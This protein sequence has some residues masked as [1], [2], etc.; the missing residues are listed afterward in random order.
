MKLVIVESPTKQKTISKFL[1]TGFTVQSSFGHIRDLPQKEFG[2]DIEKGF[3]P[4]YVVIQ[5][6][7][8]LLPTLKKLSESA[9]T[10]ILATDYDREGESIAWHLKMLLNLPKEKIQ[11]ITFHEITKTAICEALEKSRDID[12]NLVNAQQSRRIL[13]RIVGY[14]ISPILWRRI[15]SGLS[16]G[17]VQSVALRLLS[18]RELEISNFKPQ[19]FWTITAKLNPKDSNDDNLVLSS[20]LIEY[21]DKK[22]DK[23]YI[24]TQTQADGIVAELKSSRFFI[25]EIIGKEKKR[26]PMPPFITSTLQQESSRKLGFSATRTM[27]IAQE[28]Y[29][30]IE[31]GEAGSVGLITYHRTDSVQIAEI[32]RYEVRKFIKT[33]VGEQFLPDKPRFYKTKSKSAQEAHEAIRPTYANNVPENIRQHLS[34]DQ[35]KLY[36][37]IWQRFVASQ[38]NDAVF[39]TTTINIKSLD[40]VNNK[41]AIFRTTGQK[42]KFAGFLHI[43]KDHVQEEN[44]KKTVSLDA[45]LERVKLNDELLLK[46]L[47]PEQ[48]FTEPPPRYNEAS[49]IKELEKNGIGR[50]STYAP[51]ISTIIDRGYCELNQKRFFVTKLG[52]VVDKLML[53]SFPE[54]VDI[55]FTANMEQ[56]LDRIADGKDEWTNVLQTFYNSFIQTRNKALTNNERFKIAPQPSNEICPK[57]GAAM[58]IREG[59]YGKFLSCS[60]YPE[61][62][63]IIPLDKNGNKKVV[64]VTQEKC[65][66]CGKFM[67]IREGKR[68]KFMACSGFPKCR[69]IKNISKPLVE[70]NDK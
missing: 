30:G 26:Q 60:K 28:L 52:E 36:T 37:L 12:M 38:M 35:Y 59:K 42:I 68:G 66:K 6:A 18:K 39:D 8:R 5:R 53:T 65:D 55:N 70:T 22:V 9:D 17:R 43:Y 56:N 50:P 51:T 64:V 19:E 27:K 63:Q 61:C 49:L 3:V 57:C 32:A 69:N 34:A 24:K 2:V 40:S 29:E 7:N 15:K 4:K 21:K 23:L 20:E 16:A 14:K 47:L 13:D 48:H 11:R 33:N 44:D 41:L 31:L 25:N 1:G 54:I 10:I 45:I 62:K 58:V 46:E 67:V